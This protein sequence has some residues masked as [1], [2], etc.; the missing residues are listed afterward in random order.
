VQQGIVLAVI[1]SLVELIRRQYRPHRFVI[2]I[3]NAGDRSYT[4][5]EPGMQSAPGLV[6]FRYDAD[7]FYANAN[8]FADGIQQIMLQAPDPV[9]WLIIDCSSIPDVDYS[10]G[11]ALDELVTFVHSRGGVVALA[12]PD[13]EFREML[14][15]LGVLALLNTDHIYPTV[16]DAVAG[17]REAPSTQA[18][19]SPADDTA[20]DADGAA[21]QPPKS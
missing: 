1:M 8:Q 7:L 18:L 15:R 13:P 6:V 12:A 9:R 11:A 10:A 17:F 20:I 19:A 14:Q 3:D 2:G 4:K 16:E 5:A 21:D